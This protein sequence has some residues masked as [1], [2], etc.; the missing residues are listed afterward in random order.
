MKDLQTLA[1]II[2]KYSPQNYYPQKNHQNDFR[3]EIQIRFN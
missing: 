1:S 3:S 2:K